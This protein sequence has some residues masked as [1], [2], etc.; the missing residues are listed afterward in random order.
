MVGFVVGVLDFKS[1]ETI[2]LQIILFLKAKDEI[3]IRYHSGDT[4]QT[5]THWL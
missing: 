5:H 1:T 4:L 3:A 2:M